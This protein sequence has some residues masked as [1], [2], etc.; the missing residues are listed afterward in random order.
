MIKFFKPKIDG[1]IFF[2]NSMEIFYQ[3]MGFRRVYNIPKMAEMYKISD[4]WG[5]FGIKC[6]SNGS[7]AKFAD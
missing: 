5:I 6:H 1:R 7:H 2:C 3:C 4:F